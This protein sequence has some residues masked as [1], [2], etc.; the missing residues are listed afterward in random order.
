MLAEGTKLVMYALK[1][2]ASLSS[3]DICT[4]NAEIANNFIKVEGAMYVEEVLS[5][6]T[7]LHSLDIST[8]IG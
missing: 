4:F 2:N 7:E 8:H 6:N 5:A 3:L 1:E